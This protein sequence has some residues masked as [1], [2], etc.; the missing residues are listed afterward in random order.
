MAWVSFDRAASE[1][2]AEG[3]NEEA[4]RW[5]EIADE[6][7]AKVCERGFDRELNTFVQVL[8]LEA[9]SMQACC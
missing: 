1:F 3:L 2:A 6:I 7:H 8:R 9:P 5:R 4:R